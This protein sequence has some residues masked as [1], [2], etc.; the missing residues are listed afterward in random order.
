MARHGRLPHP[1]IVAAAIC[2]ALAAA[3]LALPS[4]L[5]YDQY[6]WLIWGRD[7]AHLGLSVHGTGTSWKPLPAVIDALLM[8]LGRNAPHGWLVVAR[9]GALFAMFMAFRLA[10]RLAPRG[11]GVLA[12]VIAAASL[13]LTHEWLRR[14]GVGNSEALLVAF[15]LLAVDRHLDCRHGQ[16]F[17]LLV[18]AGLIRPEM[19]L[20]IAAYALWLGW[21]SH[22][23]LRLGVALGAV[24]A[25]LLWF[26]GDWLGSGHLT[27]SADRALNSTGRVSPAL[28][29]PVL[30]VA[31]EAVRML[32][33]PA[34]IALVA[35]L[36]AALV[37]RRLTPA[38]ALAACAAVWTAVVAAMAARGYP[39][40][41]RFLFMASALEA[42]AAGVGAA[43]LVAALAR[44]KRLAR[45]ALAV[46][47]A[48]A[49]AF[50]SVPD[51]QLL[52]SEAA[53]IDKVADMDRN[54]ADSI[55]AAGG[56]SAVLRCGDPSTPWYT[57]TIVAWDLGV[58]STDV[59]DR[60]L[61]RRSV[62]FARKRGQWRVVEAHRCHNA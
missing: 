2:L 54:L 35:G 3:S 18:A 7:L 47:A 52:P 53:G 59:H 9:A 6:A 29:Q 30:T 42:V 5:N 48:G 58:P 10:W 1:L 41:P 62:S 36:L 43:V 57:V 19:W 26:G 8:P 60:R 11:L 55:Q 16:A 17:A 45:G 21:R 46:L 27:T 14:T 40:L 39:G 44:R 56:P 12:G 33:L 28:S 24:T 37:R 51:A 32:P 31:D 15:G 4:G 23:W 49:F 38:V 61:G 13:V 34:W 25:P 50:A 22:G 20:F